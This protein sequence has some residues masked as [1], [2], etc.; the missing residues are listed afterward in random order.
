MIAFP[1]KRIFGTLG[2]ERAGK[3]SLANYL[4]ETRGFEAYAFADQIKEEFGISKED[5]EAAKIAGNIKE[6][7][8]KLWA[9]SAEVKKRD[10]LY[11]IKNVMDKAAKAK[12]SVVITDIRTMDEFNAFYNMNKNDGILRR[13]YYVI[14]EKANVE[15][16]MLAG[17][18]IPMKFIL[19]E[20]DNRPYDEIRLVENFT[21]GIF[22]FNQQLD[23]IFVCDDLRDMLDNDD[24]KNMI[25]R[26]IN[27]YKVYQK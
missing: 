20:L 25:E 2:P 19:S 27:Q 6:L 11:F 16:E 13:I 8:D 10:P 12:S 22:Y 5:F 21:N 26:Y 3:N 15:E 18:K 23:K 1:K 9:F 7:R 14:R 17:S 4:V 24:D